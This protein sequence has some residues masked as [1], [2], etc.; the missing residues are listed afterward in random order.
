MALQNYTMVVWFT[1]WV[2]KLILGSQACSSQIQYLSNSTKIA[3][4]TETAMLSSCLVL[5]WAIN[6]R[7]KVHPQR[8]HPAALLVRFPRPM[9][10]NLS[11]ENFQLGIFQ[12][13]L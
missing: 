4:N 11:Q 9:S 7:H 10:F 5:K 13:T 1:Y 12:S 3:A 8:W 2:K 6:K